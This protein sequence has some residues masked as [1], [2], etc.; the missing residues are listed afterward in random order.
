LSGDRT[1]R[2]PK[3]IVALFGAAVC[4]VALSDPVRAAGVPI[5]DLQAALRSLGFLSSLEN[6]PSLSIGVVYN[7]ADPAAKAQAVR[8]AAELA[9]LPGPGS[10]T[11]SASLVAVQDMAQTSPRVD[12]LYLMPL[13]AESSRAVADFVRRQGVVSVSSDPA[14]MDMGTCVLLVQSRSSMSIVLD[15]ALAKVVGARFSSVFTMLVKRK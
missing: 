8:V 14:C 9:K 12:A 4:L 13:P 2:T 1:R 7:G 10:S 11:V 3:R 15:T 5:A 6:R